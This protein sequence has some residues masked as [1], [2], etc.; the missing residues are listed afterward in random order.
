M[1]AKIFTTAFSR[2][3]PL[4]VEHRALKEP[5]P[6]KGYLYVAQSKGGTIKCI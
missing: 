6:K 4:L 5:L 1:K 2:V 3:Y